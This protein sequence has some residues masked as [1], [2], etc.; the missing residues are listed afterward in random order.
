MDIL[1]HNFIPRPVRAPD[2]Q[3]SGK[4]VAGARP[5]AHATVISFRRKGTKA[6]KRKGYV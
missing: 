1:I 4:T 3:S 5:C 2:L 6:W